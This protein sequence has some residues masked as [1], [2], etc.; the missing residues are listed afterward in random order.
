MSPKP[1]AGETENARGIVRAE[2]VGL[3]G[4]LSVDALLRAYG[5]GLFPM[6]ERADS[7]ELFWFDPEE[8]GILPLDAFH[9][10]HRL[11]RTIRSGRFRVTV[12][13]DFTGVI[14]GCAA[15]ARGRTETWINAEIRRLFLELRDLGFAHSVETRRDG[16]L[17][18]GLYGLA[19]GGA[20]FGESMFSLETDAS[21]VALTDLVARLRAGGF[22]LLDTQFVT[23]HLARFGARAITRREYRARLGEAARLRRRFPVGPVE[24]TLAELIG[25]QSSPASAQDRTHTS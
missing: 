13:T 10:P 24:E 8:R 9:V 5:V 23:A 19:L 11:A 2:R 14:D 4:G 20:F 1:E 7:E 18:G 25:G 22:T 6:A 15:P 17:V 16:R 3:M 21:K 12:D